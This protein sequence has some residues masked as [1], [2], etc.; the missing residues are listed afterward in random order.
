MPS[1]AP[2]AQGAN[3]CL[4]PAVAFC[5][6]SCSP[7]VSPPLTSCVSSAASIRANLLSLLI[8]CWKMST[9]ILLERI[10]AD[11]L[12]HKWWGGRGGCEQ[13]CSLRPCDCKTVGVCAYTL[14]LCLHMCVH[15]FAF[16][17]SHI[18]ATSHASLSA[19]QARIEDMPSCF[20]I[21]Q[22]MLCMLMHSTTKGFYFKKKK[23]HVRINKSVMRCYLI[24][25]LCFS[26]IIKAEYWFDLW[27]LLH[28]AAVRKD[29]PWD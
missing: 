29:L 4:P 22:S 19:S 11:G 12:K 28:F 2:V 7:P 3:G 14:Q 8:Q 26:F 20:I 1:S 10:L 5:E 21:H 17:W 24:Q 16:V 23:W 6:T 27:R 9:Q 15:V 18:S 13:T 25:S